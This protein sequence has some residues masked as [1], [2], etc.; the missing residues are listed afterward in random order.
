MDK[1]QSVVWFLCLFALNVML[2]VI[3]RIEMDMSVLLESLKLY[4]IS[5]RTYIVTIY[6]EGQPSMLLIESRA[7]LKLVNE[8]QITDYSSFSMSDSFSSYTVS[9]SPTAQF[10]LQHPVLFQERSLEI[11]SPGAMSRSRLSGNRGYD[12]NQRRCLLLLYMLIFL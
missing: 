8:E 5:T 4:Y 3:F 10:G 7:Q 11:A 6:C 12:N 9:N 1:H 2:E